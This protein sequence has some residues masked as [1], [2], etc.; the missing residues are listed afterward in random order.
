M[1]NAFWQSGSDSRCLLNIFFNNLNGTRDPSRFMANTH[2]RIPFFWDPFPIQNIIST[3]VYK[4][5]QKH[6]IPWSACIIFGIIVA[7]NSCDLG[8]GNFSEIFDT[9]YLMVMYNFWRYICCIIFGSRHLKS[10]QFFLH[11]FYDFL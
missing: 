4:K 3:L 11:I 2:K 7:A 9:E 6:N 5:L 8:I 10:L 1:Q